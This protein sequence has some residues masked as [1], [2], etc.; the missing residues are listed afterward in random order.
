ML[1]CVCQSTTFHSCQNQILHCCKFCQ[2]NNSCNP[3]A[4]KVI[5]LQSHKVTIFVI[6]LNFKYSFVFIWASRVIVMTPGYHTENWKS[7]PRLIHWVGCDTHFNRS[8]S[9]FYWGPKGS[10]QYSGMVSGKERGTITSFDVMAALLFI[11]PRTR[12]AFWAVSA[13]CRFIFNCSSTNIPKSFSTGLCSIHSS[14]SLYWYQCL[15]WPMCR[16]LHLALLNFEVCKGPL[17][18]PINV[19]LD[20][21]FSLKHINCTAQL[22]VIHI[23]Q[24]AFNHMICK[25]Y[26]GLNQP[27]FGI[28]CLETTSVFFSV[29]DTKAYANNQ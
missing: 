6:L 16:N 5:S 11:E 26:S 9:L 8:M 10:T 2:V 18:K 1:L 14:S 4:L 23:G 17:L 28:T 29:Y 13:H 3:T 25:N 7:S 27:L 24:I 20:Y 12:L 15:P 22:G 19:P 21:I